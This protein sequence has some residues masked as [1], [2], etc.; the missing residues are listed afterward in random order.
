VELTDQDFERLLA[1]R[2]G[3]RRFLHWSEEQAEEVGLTPAQHQL[4]LV[5][6]GSNETHGPTI[7]SI[8][9]SLLLRHHSA[10]ELIDRAEHAGLVERRGDPDDR[11]VVRVVLTRKGH[12]MLERL[13]VRHL[14]ELHE[15]APVLEALI[16]VAGT[17]SSEVRA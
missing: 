14:E 6:R 4:L 9:D 15:L 8:G 13:T 16:K 11:R 12:G 7:G 10:V 1:F 17:P 5:I 2:L 3:L